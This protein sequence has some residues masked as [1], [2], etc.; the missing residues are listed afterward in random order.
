MS[1]CRKT[2]TGRQATIYRVQ[3]TEFR[4]RLSPSVATTSRWLEVVGAQ[5]RT[6]R[7]GRW[8]SQDEFLADSRKAGFRFSK[9]VIRTVETCRH[10]NTRAYEQ[11]ATAL[12]LKIEAR[13]LPADTT[14]DIP[15]AIYPAPVGPPM[16][17]WTSLLHYIQVIPPEDHA[18]AVSILEHWRVQKRLRRANASPLETGR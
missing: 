7:T 13:T 11:V 12:G 5:L 3:S 14:E 6:A 18:E 15:P 17:E 9:H 8:A 10:A 16:P 2:V 4:A 1:Q